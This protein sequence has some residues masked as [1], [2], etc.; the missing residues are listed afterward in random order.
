MSA[1]ITR[2][3]QEALISTKY[4]C[5]LCCFFAQASSMACSCHACGV[6]GHWFWQCTDEAALR[7]FVGEPGQWARGFCAAQHL[8][9][10]EESSGTP[11]ANKTIILS[12]LGLDNVPARRAR[13]SGHAP[14]A[15]TDAEPPALAPAAEPPAPVPA[16]EPPAPA[17]QAPVWSYSDL[18]LWVA[19]QVRKGK[20][21]F[22]RSRFAQPRRSA[23]GQ[24][25][26]CELVCQFVA[27]LES[28][29]MLEGIACSEE[30]GHTE[31]ACAEQH[32]APVWEA[33]KKHWEK[34]A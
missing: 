25:I 3:D 23:S 29:Q 11:Q 18:F 6:Q 14:P 10:V 17:A 20:A 7:S 33:A 19:R 15:P 30:R 31:L 2:G 32:G 24:S 34:T 9:W 26:P 22:L 5:L 4:I 1:D 12:V 21:D 16:A 8:T 28:C 27:A 13:F